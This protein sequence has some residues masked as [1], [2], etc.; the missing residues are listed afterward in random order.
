MYQQIE[1]LSK[2]KKFNKN[3]KIDQKF[4]KK[5]FKKLFTVVLPYF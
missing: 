2:I 1:N 3:F 4:M 5:I